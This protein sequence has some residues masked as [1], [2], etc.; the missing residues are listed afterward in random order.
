MSTKDSSAELQLGGRCVLGVHL[1]ID[2]L[3]MAEVCRGRIA[4]WANVPYPTGLHPGSK[5]FPA[6]LKT[7]LSG[8]HPGSPHAALWVVGPTPSLQVRFLSLPKARPRQ[9]AN[10]AYWTF[11]K[12]I[13]FDAA[14]TTFDYDVEG[15]LA[16]GTAARKTEVTAY[17]VTQAD[18][19][20]LADLCE[21]AG[22]QADGI[23][24]P[25]FALR[26]LFHGQAATHAGPVLG[27]FVG[28]DASSLLFFKD[29]QVVAHRVFKTG[30]NVMLDVLRD[31]HPDWSPAKTYRTIRAALASSA[32]AEPTADNDRATEARSIS[33]TVQTA[34]TRLVQQVE[35]S[36]SAYLVG[37]SNEEIR[38]IYIAGAVAGLPTLVQALGAKLGL[39]SQPLNLFLPGHMESGA[40]P[41]PTAEEAGM[42]AI[43]LGAAMS[44]AARTPN[45]L[46]TYVKRMEETR[47][48][49]WRLAGTLAGVAGLVLLLGAGTWLGRL[50]RNSKA[51]LDSIRQQ[52][53]T[54]APYPDR[55]LIEA[56]V[57]KASAHSL[58]LKE[59]AG[60]SLPLAALN[61]IAAQTPEDIRLTAIALQRDA[62][63][64]TDKRASKSGNGGKPAP[65]WLVQAEGMVLGPP[66]AQESKLASYMVRLEDSD[67]FQQIELQ[68]SAE[69]R[70]GS[71]QVLLFE[72]ALKMDDLIREPTSG[73][74]LAPEK[75]AVP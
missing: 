72:L 51:E 70:E 24:I 67:P 31:R 23:M 63:Q 54:F 29:K 75:G 59:M 11:R 12:E 6:F 8:F 45:L 1:D 3:R 7:S 14:Q 13:P 56:M 65:H 64:A 46:H 32:S 2:S 62:G 4:K 68:H 60:R 73:A 52:I 47:T 37:R 17:T 58:Q 57:D 27:L 35:R 38:H 49:H 74:D 15:D 18:V 61:R 20:A 66:G 28:E 33:E 36:M 44:D 9:M 19:E 34:F 25:S 16:A 69:G 10:L 39:V 53:E 41:P 48:A 22:L 55:A 71:S 21:R 26:N 50:N 30:M 40:I 5:D 43:A 42:M